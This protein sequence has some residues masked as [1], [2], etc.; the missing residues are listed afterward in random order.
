M[1]KNL[2]VV[3]CRPSSTDKQQLKVLPLLLLM[4]AAPAMVWLGAANAAFIVE[5]SGGQTATHDTVTD[6]YWYTDLPFF[7]GATSLS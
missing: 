2:D 6:K 4:L 3:G 1:S 5:T 7:G